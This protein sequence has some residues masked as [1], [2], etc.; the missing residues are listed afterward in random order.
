MSNTPNKH[1]PLGTLL[2]IFAGFSLFALIVAVAYYPQRPPA[3]VQGALTPEERAAR[4]L[5]MHSKEQKQAHSYA[6]IDQQKGQ[7]Q[8]PIERA[9]ELTVQDLNSKK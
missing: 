5:E 6:W 7:V 1:L 3:L 9:M 4:L 8:L 2:A